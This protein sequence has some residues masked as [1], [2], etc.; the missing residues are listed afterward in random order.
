MRNKIAIFIFS[1]VVMQLAGVIGAFFNLSSIDSWYPT[2]VKPALNPPGWVFGPV[3]TMLFLLI[4]I[5]FYFVLV[6]P[7]GK[8]KTAAITVFIVQWLLNVAWSFFFFYLQNPFFALI[9]IVLLLMS[10]IAMIIVFARIDKRSAYL[11]I[12]Y[13]AWVTFASYLNYSIWSLNS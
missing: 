2:L 10:I 1:V 5:A 12:P 7:A 4:G 13:L 8:M 6:S 9:E 11:L 3:W